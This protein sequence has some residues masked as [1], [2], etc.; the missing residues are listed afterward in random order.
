MIK[1]AIDNPEAP[2]LASFSWGLRIS[3]VHEFLILTGRGDVGSDRQVRHPGDAMAQANAILAE[4]DALLRHAGYDRDSIVRMDLT[5]TEA[6]DHGTLEEIMGVWADFVSPARI[7]P[8]AGTIRIVNGLG[9]DEMLVEFEL[10]A[11]K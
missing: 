3:D 6:V 5:V 9:R 2:Q 11:A 4:Y 7:K 1:Q 8:A 10:Q